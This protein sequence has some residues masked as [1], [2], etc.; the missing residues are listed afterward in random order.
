MVCKNIIKQ[1]VPNEGMH[2]EKIETLNVLQGGEFSDAKSDEGQPEHLEKDLS[3]IVKIINRQVVKSEYFWHF[4][5]VHDPVR[6][7]IIAEN[8]RE[9]HFIEI[10][11]DDLR[12]VVNIEKSHVGQHF[13]EHNS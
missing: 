1:Q 3:H 9:A 10:H 11:V 13:E 8:P 7:L 12:R 6:K 5:L 2:Q 4:F